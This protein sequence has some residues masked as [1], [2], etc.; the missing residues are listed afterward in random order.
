VRVLFTMQLVDRR[1]EQEF[2]RRLRRELDAIDVPSR[3]FPPL[4]TSRLPIRTIVIA[5]AG[6]L[7]LSAAVGAITGSA[8]PGA[9]G[10]WVQKTMHAVGIAASP[11]LIPTPPPAA[12][13]TPS[14]ATVKLVAK[15]PAA[16]PG[17][18]PGEATSSSTS[19]ESPEPTQSEPPE[20]SQASPGRT[21]SPTPDEVSGT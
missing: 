16:V 12:S 7:A 14:P 20:S 11:S 3:P 6:A 4:A 21:S 9:W 5:A 18:E 13:P 2:A 15:S 10:G 19:H 17:R 1:F 8:N